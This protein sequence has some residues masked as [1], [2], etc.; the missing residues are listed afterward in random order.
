VKIDNQ[1]RKQLAG[2][3]KQQDLTG[4]QGVKSLLEPCCVLIKLSWR[5]DGRIDI[6]KNKTLEFFAT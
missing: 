6:A 5:H 4:S 2:Q 1:N 3:N